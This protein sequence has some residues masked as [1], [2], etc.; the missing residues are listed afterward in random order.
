MCSTIADTFESTAFLM[1]GVSVFAASYPISKIGFLGYFF[2]FLFLIIA[3]AGNVFL[4]S[5]IINLT[6]KKFLNWN[7]QFILW[8]SGLRGAMGKLTSICLISNEYKQ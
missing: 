2:N 5:L 1:I 4:I 6:K 8:F 3:R 7:F